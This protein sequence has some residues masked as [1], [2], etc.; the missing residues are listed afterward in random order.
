MTMEN[1]NEEQNARAD[2]LVVA[3]NNLVRSGA[4]GSTSTLVEDIEVEDLVDLAEWVISGRHPMDRYDAK[5]SIELPTG[6]PVL[7]VVADAPEL[8]EHKQVTDVLSLHPGQKAG[9]TCTCG[10]HSHTK[11][12]TEHAAD[13]LRYDQEETT[14]THDDGPQFDGDDG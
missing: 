13:V 5:T 10:W 14:L 4:L 3:K 1:L 11:T 6:P 2:A 9:A 7:G 12:W 8:T